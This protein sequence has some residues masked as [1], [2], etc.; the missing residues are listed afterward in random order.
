MKTASPLRTGLIAAQ[1]GTKPVTTTSF[2]PRAGFFC[3]ISSIASCAVGAGLLTHG[4]AL[5]TF[6][7]AAAA[8]NAA[9]GFFIGGVALLGVGLVLGA[10]MAYKTIRK[11]YF[12][13]QS[14][15]LSLQKP[16]SPPVAP[17]IP[18][19][20]NKKTSTNSDSKKD[21]SAEKDSG[22]KKDLYTESTSIPQTSENL[23]SSSD[24]AKRKLPVF[25]PS[26][27]SNSSPFGSKPK[28]VHTLDFNADF[29]TPPMKSR[30]QSRS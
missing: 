9:T 25:T 15:H 14:N 22:T 17:A 27:Q 18:S 3:G 1:F 16:P 12:V 10:I 13:N 29:M 19:L 8:A 11:K 24:S 2:K 23:N 28:V 7:T 6:A 30:R 26:D 5:G 20:S 21:S 4:L